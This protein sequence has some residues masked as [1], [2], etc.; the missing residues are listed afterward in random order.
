M[1][2]PLEFRV[3]GNLLGIFPDLIKQDTVCRGCIEREWATFRNMDASIL[4]PASAKR[5]FYKM[6][7]RSQFPCTVVAF[8]ILFGRPSSWWQFTNPTFIRRVIYTPRRVP[9]MI[10][11]SGRCLTGFFER[12]KTN[13]WPK[14]ECVSFVPQ[15]E[16]RN[17]ENSRLEFSSSIR[18][19]S[20]DSVT[21]CWA[22]IKAWPA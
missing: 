18:H 6:Q 9:Q 7:S 8:V 10:Q 17:W 11:M 13:L 4:S 12:G 16:E 2:V 5:E 14:V 20:V 22:F 19:M 3:V 1:H 21:S 15:R